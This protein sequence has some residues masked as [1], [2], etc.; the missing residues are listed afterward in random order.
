MGTSRPQGG[1]HGGL[2]KQGVPG[3]G[4]TVTPRRGGRGHGDPPKWGPGQPAPPGCCSVSPSV[5]PQ[6]LR[7]VPV[8]V[9]PC[10]LHMSLPCPHVSP[11]HVPICPRS[12]SPSSPWAWGHSVPLRSCVIS[13]MCP[14]PS[15]PHVTPLCPPVCPSSH[16]V[17]GHS[18]PPPSCV[19][20][21]PPCPH[22]SPL[23]PGGGE[24][25]AP[26]PQHG[27]RPPRT[28]HLTPPP[29]PPPTEP[30]L[31][32]HPRGGPLSP[33]LVPELG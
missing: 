31:P 33:L 13:P 16:W 29:P 17:Q 11:P 3:F 26:P 5:S 15:V 22:M 4:D 6:I 21:P 12:V 23:S 8:P 32:P 7:C 19:V 28:P 24:D 25:P 20:S 2:L 30:A 18:I 1:C 27:P 9:S 14:H 10:A